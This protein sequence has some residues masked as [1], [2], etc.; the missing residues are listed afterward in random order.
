MPFAP[1]QRP[2]YP[3]RQWSIVGRPGSGKSTFAAA[4]MRTP[5]L[6]IDADQRFA[7]V[8]HLAGGE[9]YQLSEDPTANTDARRI[10]DL[11]AAN[12]RGSGVKT[13]VIDSLTA[14]IA[15]LISAAIMANEAGENKNRIAAFQP[16]AMAMRTIQDAATGTGADTLWIY[17]L[18]DGRDGKAKAR[19][20]TTITPVELARLRRSLNMELS[21]DDRPD[22]TR[23]ITADWCRAGRSGFTLIDAPG[24]QWAGMA[25]RIEA[26]AY[27]GLTDAD[28]QALATETP[29]TFAGKPAAIAWG[30][31]QGCFR[32][33]V[34]AKGAYEKLKRA[35]PQISSADQFWPIWIADVERREEE[36][37]A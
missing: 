13:I 17:H 4:A 5:I 34:H 12:M 11:I 10:A 7:Q 37:H 33:A 20:T 24:N 8:A 27:D 23:A 2:E 1:M 9:V 18:Q 3:P 21:I 25:E 15:P 19:T 16:K 35:H 29:A 28:R 6:A 26:A 32:D 14:I 22:G 31:E 30:F 36:A